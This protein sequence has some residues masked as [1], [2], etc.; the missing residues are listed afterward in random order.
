MAAAH[1][2]AFTFLFRRRGA[3]AAGFFLALSA[4][5]LAAAG[6]WRKAA[7]I[8][9]LAAAAALLTAGGGAIGRLLLP[10][11]SLSLGTSLGFGVLAV[12]WAVSLKL[13]AGVFRPWMGAAAIA[14]LGIW[15]L[16]A[17]RRRLAAPRPAPVWTG[18]SAAA[19]EC[20]FWLAAAEL[21][22]L[23]A[24]VA[25]VR[26]LAPESGFDALTRYL[27]WVK[28]A[29]RTGGFPNIPWNYPFVLPQAGL[30]WAAAFAFDPVAQRAAMLLPLAACC[31]IV[32]ARVRATRGISALVVLALV[33]SPLVVS[34][35]RGLQPDPVGWTAILL[36]TALVCDASDA[37]SRKFW[38]ACGALGAFAWCAKY[39]TA[40][41]AA[42]LVGYAVW[43][44]WKSAGAGRA[45]FRAIVFGGAGAIAAGA[46]WLIHAWRESRNPFFPLL[47]SVFP[48]PLWR[49]RIDATWGEGSVLLKGWRGLLFWPI[50][51]T[52]H[53]NR[54]GETHAGSFG[55]ALLLFLFLGI[56][57][58][59]AT[60]R[61]DRVWIVAGVAGTL[62]LWTRTPYLRY[63][64]PGLWLAVPA[65]G[66]GAARI[67]ERIGTRALAI[68]LAG[69]VALQTALAALPS[70]PDLQGLP[71]AVYTGRMTEEAY[72]ARAPGASALARLSAIDRGWPK[73][74][75]T[76]L[77]AVGQA[78]VVPIMGERWELAFHVPPQDRAGLFGY[79]DS[80]G[81][82]Y[83]AVGNA[84][85]DR[86]AYE[87]LGIADRYWRSSQVVVRD[88]TA[89]IYKIAP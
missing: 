20:P 4:V 41:F 2:A 87:A 74:W 60:D 39:S 22:F 56:C 32:F 43:R 82:R 78:N 67:A 49:M 29:A 66:R 21:S 76:G 11:G 14:A 40:G 62:L 52:I 10:D 42:P 1:A 73:T 81:C 18:A 45:L 51:M 75:Y 86:A 61:A 69:I 57:S 37:A 88:E 30:A 85:P 50:D 46:P 25:V 24:A 54:F 38:L 59:R 84:L 71:W 44:A 13:S 77:Y 53:T 12:S 58:L 6:G 89:T 36:L 70:K 8:A 63:W 9:V 72:V 16:A 5:G 34:A 15:G 26:S 64:L 27:P 83:W 7:A 28:I 47:S 31:G 79:V 68:A 80:V 23:L 55:L 17:R 48:S 35:G 65:A 19:A 33:S 3:R